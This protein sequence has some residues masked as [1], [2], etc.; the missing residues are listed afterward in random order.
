ML[1]WKRSISVLALGLLV[2]LAPAVNVWAAQATS[3]SYSVDQVFFGNG[4]ELN[5]CSSSYC[6]KQAAGETTVGN[7]SSATT[8]AQTG[9]NVDRQEYLEFKV[10]ASNLDLGVLSTS[11]TKTG[12][13]TFSVKAYLASGYQVVTVSDPPK[14]AAHIMNGMA[15]TAA[16]VVGTEQF[17]INLVANTSPATLGANPVQVPSST[18]SFGTAAAGYNTPNQY[19]YVKGSVIA[20]AL[21]S[22]GETDYTISYIMNISNVTAGGAYAMSHDLVATATF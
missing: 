5:A 14:N 18:Y 19:K 10:N 3:S 22:S 16:S 4:G 7:T 11:T 1:S 6:S 15:S 21:S 2:V 20:Q 9:F 12:T 13:A 8:Q 17:G